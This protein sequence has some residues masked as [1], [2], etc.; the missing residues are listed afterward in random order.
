LEEII[1][2]RF[3]AGLSVKETAD[4]LD[5]SVRTVER[6]SQRARSYLLSALEAE[7]E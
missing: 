2:C 5:T 4:A 3:F 6:G 1:E 7:G